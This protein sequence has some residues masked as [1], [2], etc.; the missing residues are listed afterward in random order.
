MYAT[1][2]K[3]GTSTNYEMIVE[4]KFTLMVI[5]GFSESRDIQTF[6]TTNRNDCASGFRIFHCANAHKFPNRSSFLA[7]CRMTQN[8]FH[9]ALFHLDYGRRYSSLLHLNFYFHGEI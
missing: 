9:C 2:G 6:K 3:M 7:H 8:E 4:H 1:L 5:Y